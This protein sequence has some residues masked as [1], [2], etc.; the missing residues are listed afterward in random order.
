VDEVIEIGEVDLAG[1]L[2][3]FHRVDWEFEADRLQFLQKTMPAIGVTNHAN[4]AILWT[5]PYRPL[6]PDFLDED[7][8]RRNMA[9]WYVVRLD[10]PPDPPAVT[11][12][13]TGKQLSDCYFETYEDY[14]IERLFEWFFAD[15]YKSIYASL[16]S[17]RVAEIVF[18]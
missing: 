6:P 8:F 11:E 15:D 13:K 14:E 4:G 18:E 16:Y 12:L 10:N 2:A 5:S 3:E 9:I 1:F 7:E 17:M